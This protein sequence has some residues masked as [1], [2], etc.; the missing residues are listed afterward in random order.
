MSR[1]RIHLAV[2][3]AIAQVT[4]VAALASLARAS[5]YVVMIPLESSIYDE[6]NTLDGLGYLDTYFPAIKPIARVEAARLTLEAEHNM[7]LEDKYEPL[8]VKLTQVLEEQLSD[9][10][11][12]LRSGNE[13][14]PPAAIASFNDAEVEGVFSQGTRRYWNTGI[15]PGISQ[16]I[17]T[18]GT[19]LMENADGI[20]TSQ[21][22]NEIVKAGGWLGV[23]S[24]LTLYGQ[25]TVAGPLTRDISKQ[26]RVMP[27]TAESVVSLGNQAISFGLEEKRWG[28]GYFAPLSAG[29]NA[30]P[31]P[32]VTW[33][34]VHP[35]YLPSFLRYLGPGRRE[36][37]MG[38]LDPYRDT[39]QHPWE[40]GHIMFFRPL[41]WFEF[42]FSREVI[43]GGRGNDHYDFSGFMERYWGL[44][45]NTGGTHNRGELFLKFIIP[46]W[47]GLQIYQGMLGEDNLANEIPGIGRLMPFKS[48]SYQGGAYL[49]R[50]TKD[51]LTDFRVE[52]AILPSGYS[53]HAGG[54]YST[55]Q[56]QLTGNP[57]GPNASSVNL[58]VG[59]WVELRNKFS[60]ELFWTQQAPNIGTNTPYPG[61]YYPYSLTFEQSI[62]AAVDMLRL[63]EREPWLG[64]S[65]LGVRAR[66]AT[67]YAN[68]IN[69][70]PS[71]HSWRLLL[72]LTFSLQPNM[73][74]WEHN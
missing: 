21:G 58:M 74:H 42:G 6:L 55:Y 63:P 16:L 66:V 7:A 36:M 71:I 45:T 1:R 19:P 17:A 29:A 43:F 46:R 14:N 68:H 20:P 41:P 2:C 49:P 26:Q 28:E 12:W 24:F 48:V 9:E 50:L 72:D 51:G 33:Q 27:I 30:Q 67:E 5:T 35:R 15:K 25:G 61:R 59:R 70:D 53:S 54:I 3:V 62:G 37:F 23:G 73:A 4:L 56:Y 52:W 47:R 10:V 13:D 32:A 38:Q 11:G 60:G 22:T 65:L 8:A 44:S 31:Y 34:N 39:A 57:L 64:D 40:I 69:Y 18:E